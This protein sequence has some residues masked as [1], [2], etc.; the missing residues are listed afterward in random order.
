LQILMGCVSSALMAWF[1]HGTPMPLAIYLAFCMTVAFVAVRW[2]VA[3]STAGA[4][5]AG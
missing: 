4:T 5:A 3:D 2:V 1:S